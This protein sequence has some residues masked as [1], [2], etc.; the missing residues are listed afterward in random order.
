MEGLR[1]AALPIVVQLCANVPEHE[2]LELTHSIFLLIDDL[3]SLVVV[4]EAEDRDIKTN[5]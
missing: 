3:I 5:K 2:L 1:A 4:Q